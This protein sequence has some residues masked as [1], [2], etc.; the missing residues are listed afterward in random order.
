MHMCNVG[1]VLIFKCWSVV[2]YQIIK[3]ISHF[4]LKSDGI[5]PTVYISLANA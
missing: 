1:S 5:C 3:Y 4:I 2:V